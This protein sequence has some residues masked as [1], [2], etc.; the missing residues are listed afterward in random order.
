MIKNNTKKL[1]FAFEISKNK[2]K[3]LLFRTV[4]LNVNLSTVKNRQKKIDYLTKKL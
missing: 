3:K 4:N 2:S 1:G